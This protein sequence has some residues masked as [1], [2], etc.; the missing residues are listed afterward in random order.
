MSACGKTV[1]DSP[2]AYMSP[3]FSRKR[4]RSTQEDVLDILCNTVKRM[5]KQIKDNEEKIIELSEK[6]SRLEHEFT[7]EKWISPFV[8][9]EVYGISCPIWGKQKK[10]PKVHKL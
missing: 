10:M 6:C 7:T 1:S 8:D 9:H 4:E 5:A 2:L 3:Q